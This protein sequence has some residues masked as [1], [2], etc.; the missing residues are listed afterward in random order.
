MAVPKRKT[1]LSR[2]RMRRAHHALGKPGLRPCSN[3]GSYG[4]PHRICAQCGFYDG[5]QVLMPKVKKA[6]GDE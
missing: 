2:K 1:S 6:K 3:C 4:L 5:K